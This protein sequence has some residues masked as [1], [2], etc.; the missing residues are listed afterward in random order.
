[1]TPSPYLPEGIVLE[2]L[3]PR[4]QQTIGRQVTFLTAYQEVGTITA[5]AEA[6]GIT[7]HCASLWQ[8]GDIHGFR[9]RFSLAQAAFNDSLE[10]LAISRVRDPQ[11]NRG[12]DILLLAL[13]NAHKPAKY[14]PNV[15]PVDNSSK[16]I[17]KALL[18]VSR[19]DW[20]REREVIDVEAKV[21]DGDSGESSGGGE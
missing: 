18:K 1:M 13:L 16:E 6:T 9:A 10:N 12:S 4:D 11:G 17:L 5:A 21:V 3:V 7:P 14:R 2:G 15:Q 20:E 8:R 19:K